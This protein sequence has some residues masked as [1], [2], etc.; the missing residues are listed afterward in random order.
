MSVRTTVHGVDTRDLITGRKDFHSGGRAYSGSW[1]F[2]GDSADSVSLYWSSGRL[3]SKYVET[4]TARRTAGTL[5]FVVWSY[6]TPI[7]WHCTVDGWTVPREKYSPS[8]T[9]HQTSVRS[10]LSEIG[11]K[12]A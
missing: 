3:P 12:D 8:T 7:A 2:R 5:T 10:A 1:N 4:L 6:G 9:N 11:Y